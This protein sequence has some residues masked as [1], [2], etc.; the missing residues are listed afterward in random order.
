M[1]GRMTIGLQINQTDSG[2]CRLIIAGASDWAREHGYNL[3]VF[4]G[5]TIGSPYSHE[6]QNNTVFD[7]IRPET[8]DALIITTGTQSNFLSREE[9]ERYI[10]HYA[11]IPTVSIGI[12]IEGT[13]SILIDNETG[14]RLAMEHLAV[15]HGYKRIAF[16]K[17]RDSNEEAETRLAAY[18]KA[19]KKHGLD[20]D[21]DLCIPGDFTRPGARFALAGYLNLHGTADFQAILAANDEMAIA[22]AEVL[23]ERG[24]AVPKDV[25]VVGFDNIEVSRF[26]SN[27]LTTIG[28]PLY[29][30]GRTGA[31]FAVRLFQKEPVPE[32]VVL[33]TRLVPR[34]S[35]GCLP[36]SVADL[37]WLPAAPIS[38]GPKGAHPEKRAI[39][40]RCFIRLTEKEFILPDPSLRENLEALI[41]LAGTDGFIGFFHD[42]LNQLLRR[43]V[44]ISIWQMLLAILHEELLGAGKSAE[45]FIA[46]SNCFLRARALL[47]EM[48]LAQQGKGRTDLQGQLLSLRLIMERLISVVSIEELMNDL[49]RD[50]ERLDI[51]TC[52]IAGYNPEIRHRRGEDWKTPA[53]A[54][55]MLSLVD[56]RRIAPTDEERVFSPGKHPIPPGFLPKD[57]RHTLV[58]ASLYFREDQIGYIVFEPGDR[59]ASIYET[60]CVQLSN[61]LK[62]SL[63]FTAKRKA[64]D[65]LRQV[66]SEL[67]EYNQKLSGLSQTDDLTGLLNR[68]G[69][70]SLGKQNLTLSRRMGRRGNVFFADLDDLKVINDTYG[71]QEGDLV[72]RQAAEILMKTFRN[73]DVV[74]RLGGDEF[75]ILTIDTGPEFIATLR[76]RLESCI[77]SYN[78]ESG[79]PYKLSMSVGAVPFTRDSSVS[80]EELLDNADDVL[81]SEKKKRKGV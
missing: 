75:A 21:P 73:I 11:E 27:P 5:R 39:V 47:A 9:L 34:T 37:N 74:S 72:I 31:D 25:A 41:D 7:F 32:A 30:M 42:M 43:N 6:Y 71:H 19:V 16:L 24:F 29:E 61:I 18:L 28:Q 69:F 35:C 12:K 40:E 52:F 1:S 70:L 80:L 3:L 22:A 62:G 53:R 77:A 64:E 48:L 54:E 4:S 17:G 81:Y 26:V 13:P 15:T 44:D 65:K 57:R 79:K 66:L 38:S 68:R 63:L 8:V 76:D 14:I 45:A 56:G 60:F 78:A 10:R 20:D 49:T 33:P 58:M 67:E 55:I 23:N 2:Y 50:L 46:L 36:Q 51:K 59:D